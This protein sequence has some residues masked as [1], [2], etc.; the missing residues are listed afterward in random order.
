MNYSKREKYVSF[1]LAFVIPVVI[2]LVVCALQGI[3]PFG[4][5]SILTGDLQYQFIDYLSYFKSVILTKNDFTYTFSKTMGGDM[6]GFASYYLSNPFNFLMLLFSER[7]LPLG[8]MIMI[9]LQCA[10]MSLSFQF[11]MTEIYGYRRES[12]IFAITYSLTGYVVVYFQLYAY[13]IDFIILPFIILGIHRLLSDPKKKTVY[14]ISLFLSVSLIF[15]IGWMLCIFSVLYFLYQLFLQRKGIREIISFGVSSLIAGGMS[16]VILLPAMLSLRG[17]KDN[18]HIGFYR[19]MSMTDLFSRLYTNTFKGNISTCLPNIYCGVLVVVL[20]ALYFFNKKIELRERIVS[21]VFIV[22]FLVNFYI[23]TLNVV[24]H[25]FNSPIGFPYRYSFLLIYMLLILGYR[26]ITEMDDSRLL[27]KLSVIFFI[28]ICYSGFLML[29]GSEVVGKKEIALDAVILVIILA[30]IFLYMKKKIAAGVFIGALLAIQIFDI[31]ENLHNSFYYFGFLD[32]AEYQNYIDE[33]G[34]IVDDIKSKDDGFYRMEKYFR[35]THNDALQFQ[36][37]GLTHFS[38]CEKK[39]VIEYMGKLGF[40]DN[41]NW[42]FYDTGSTALLDSLFGLKYI[43]SQHSGTGKP[44]EKISENIY[45]DNKYYTYKNQFAL[46]MVFTADEGIYNIKMEGNDPFAFQESI[47]DAINNRENRILREGKVSQISLINLREISRDGE[48]VTYEKIDKEKDG[49]IDYE[50]PVEEENNKLLFMVYFNADYLQNASIYK[51]NEDMGPYFDKYY[52]K[53]IDMGQKSAG[54]SYHI[55]VY[56]WDDTLNISGAH[57]YFEDYDCLAKWYDEVVSDECSLNMITSSHLKGE[58]NVSE[59]KDI[60]FSFPYE[61]SWEVLVD[62]KTAI[63]KK[64]AGMMLGAEADPGK[65]EIELIYHPAG[66]VAGL[67][68]SILSIIAMIVVELI[69]RHYILCVKN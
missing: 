8:F 57:F 40:R 7:L 30:I 36:Y 39:E 18:F 32:L 51:K 59:G 61:E 53:I 14:I 66:R 44:Y 22:F 31:G 6:A 50:I 17:E 63:T 2:W 54:K 16:A 11:V 5:K 10:L 37:N 23:N 69:D 42:S 45:E 27:I 64:A 21:A 4:G 48:S 29:R 25:G 46:P 33:V 47:A 1:V 67:I 28:Y 41:G 35:R 19:T 13:F 65:H 68:I 49:Y 43:L 62:G 26:S 58:V 24:W 38:S 12:L 52:W 9:I 3:Y 56:G 34:S 55:R 60:I 15:Y 20:V